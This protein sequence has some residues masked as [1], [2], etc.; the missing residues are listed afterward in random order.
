MNVS[1]GA[2]TINLHNR[3]RQLHTFIDAKIYELIRRVLV[4]V[5]C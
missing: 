1:F 4:L 2:V 5:N 3:L